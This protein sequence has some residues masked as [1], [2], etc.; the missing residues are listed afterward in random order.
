MEPTTYKDIIGYT[1]IQAWRI[2]GC[3]KRSYISTLISSGKLTVVGEIPHRGNNRKLLKVQDV[4]DYAAS[5][6]AKGGDIHYFQ[7]KLTKVQLLALQEAFP[8]LK[9]EDLTARRREAYLSS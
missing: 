2:I 6:E 7:V 8:N 4:L 3:A 1:I 5:F 9:F